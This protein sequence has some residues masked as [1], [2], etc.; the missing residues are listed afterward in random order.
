MENIEEFNVADTMLWQ[1]VKEGLTR[2]WLENETD[3]R[4]VEYL[5]EVYNDEYDGGIFENI[6]DAIYDAFR[7]VNEAFDC[8]VNSQ[9]NY[10]NCDDWFKVE[11]YDNVLCSYSNYDMLEKLRDE[12]CSDIRYLAENIEE[13]KIDPD[14]T[15]IEIVKDIT[16][17]Q[18]HYKKELEVINS[19]LNKYIEENTKEGY[20]IS[21]IKESN[22]VRLESVTPY[23]FVT[24]SEEL[25]K[26]LADR[27]DGIQALLD[28]NSAFFKGALYNTMIENNAK[29]YNEVACQ[30]TSF[31][32]LD[33]EFIER[34]QQEIDEVNLNFA[35]IGEFIQ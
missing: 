20:M 34:H 2:K 29:S 6:E 3:E 13:N 24:K 19:D 11:S 9:G 14:G 5:V 31:Y 17:T 30:F 10:D 16:L 33:N 7:D 15:Y 26:L 35:K 28:C 25:N 1:K 4:D 32:N 22:V 23:Q 27:N 21:H 12:M 18:R 8:G